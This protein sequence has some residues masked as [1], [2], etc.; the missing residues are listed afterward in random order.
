M[1]SAAVLI[2]LLC[3]SASAQDDDVPVEDSEDV[4]PLVSMPELLEYVQAPYP[5]AAKE[6]GVEGT[7]RLL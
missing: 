4:K 5:E 6:A 7:V 2:G 1:I 3:G